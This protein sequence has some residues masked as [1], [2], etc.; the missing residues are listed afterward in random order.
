MLKNITS[1]VNYFRKTYLY[2]ASIVDYIS[3]DTDIQRHTVKL[4]ETI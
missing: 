1:T 4:V 2:K 3:I